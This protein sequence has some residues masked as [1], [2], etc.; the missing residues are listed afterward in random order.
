MVC[1]GHLSAVAPRK[2]TSS[3]APQQLD[4]AMALRSQQHH[5]EPGVAAL[6]VLPRYG[7]PPAPLAAGSAE[8]A[9]R[10]VSNRWPPPGTAASGVMGAVPPAAAAAQVWFTPCMTLS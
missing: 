6:P 5:P 10:N 9:R 3:E 7:W 8:R 1:A 2:P 4:S